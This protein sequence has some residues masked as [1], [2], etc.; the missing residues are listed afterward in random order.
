MKK[1]LSVIWHYTSMTVCL[2]GATFLAIIAT[3]KLMTTK[4]E[5][6]ILSLSC[7]VLYLMLYIGIKNGVFK[8]INALVKAKNG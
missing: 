7:S 5:E 3:A 4:P 6:A 8:K 2:V 1:T